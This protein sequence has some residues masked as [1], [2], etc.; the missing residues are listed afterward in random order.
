M[1][2]RLIA[3]F[4]HRRM[5]PLLCNEWQQSFTPR[6]LKFINLPAD[7]VIRIFNLNGELVRTIQ[8]TSTLEPGI[9]E[10]EIFGSAGGDEWW[11]LL[12]ANNQL[13]ASGVYI[14]HI[15]SDVGE[16]IGKF[17]VIR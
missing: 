5:L 7:C 1:C 8:H 16:Q 6:R 15:D 4:R 9:G 3:M 11:D 13:V 12:S 17:V 14:F 10:Q 2:M